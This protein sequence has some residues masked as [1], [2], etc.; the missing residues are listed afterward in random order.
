VRYYA[1]WFLLAVVGL[2]C[3]SLE[4]CMPC[5]ETPCCS[6]ANALC[7][8]SSAVLPPAAPPAAPCPPPQVEFR[9]LEAIHVKAP[10]QKVVITTPAPVEQ[11]AVTPQAVAPQVV[12]AQ[13]APAQAQAA[14][15]APFAAMAFS[16]AGPATI[17]SVPANRARLAL[18]L[19]TIRVP[20]PFPRFYAV[21]ETQEVTMP[22]QQTIVQGQ[23]FPAPVQAA[24]FAVQAQALPAQ[25]IPVQSA[26]APVTV[27]AQAMP[28]QLVPVQ[29]QAQMV[30]VQ[31]VAMPVQQTIV[32]GQAFP[33]PVQAQAFPAPVVPVQA[34]ALPAQMIPVQPVTPCP[35][36]P[37]CPSQTATQQKLDEC[38]RELQTLKAMINQQYGP[39]PSP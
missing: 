9:A 33:V 25:M 18:G 36:C 37:P 11:E 5:C 22:V 20:I 3:H 10:R 34:Q 21:P 23:A 12:Y 38:N 4:N 32:Q 15:V 16:A 29:A 39:K 19:E 8:E 26:P 28:S 1:P 17:Q 35:P 27:Q 30:P 24:S 13:A 31:A 7:H 14:P 2:G 6:A